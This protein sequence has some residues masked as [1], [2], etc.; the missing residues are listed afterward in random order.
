MLLRAVTLALGYSAVRVEPIEQIVKLL[1]AGITPVVPRY[2][3]VGASGDLIPSAYISATVEL[4]LRT[5]T[6]ASVQSM[7][8]NHGLAIAFQPGL[9][10]TR[11]SVLVATG[12]PEARTVVEAAST[13]PK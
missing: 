4:P 13:I 9:I 7:A 3:S 12:W 5:D 8:E 6:C 11:Y 10:A 2:G 1:N